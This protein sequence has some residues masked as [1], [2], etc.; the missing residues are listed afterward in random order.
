MHCIPGYTGGKS[1]L[2]PELTLVGLG[3]EVDCPVGFQGLV[4][5]APSLGYRVHDFVTVRSAC[6]G[7]SSSGV[8][9]AKL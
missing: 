9:V 5:H 6:K 3:M 1:R 4:H 8:R 7:C 2:I